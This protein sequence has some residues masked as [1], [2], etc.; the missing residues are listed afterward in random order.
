MKM[1]NI[2]GGITADIEGNPY[3]QLIMGES[4]PGKI[5][6][7]YGGV[8]RNITENLARLGAEVGFVSVAGDAFS[9]AI[10]DGFV[11]GM[12]VE[13][14]AKYGMAAV[15][16]AMESKTPVNPKICFEEVMRRMKNE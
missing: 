6:M 2:I 7:S 12:N 11:K 14:T 13:E 10:L 8:G 1:I 5:T 3:G 15:S 9:A 16:V 4:N